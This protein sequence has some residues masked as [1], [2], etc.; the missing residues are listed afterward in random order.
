MKR[1]RLTVVCQGLAPARLYIECVY[2]AAVRVL[3]VAETWRVSQY[4]IQPVCSNRKRRQYLMT[5]HTSIVS[6]AVN[7]DTEVSRMTLYRRDYYALSR[8]CIC[9]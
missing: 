1:Y 5:R 8:I 4:E 9:M 3:S 6:R 2:F 7:F